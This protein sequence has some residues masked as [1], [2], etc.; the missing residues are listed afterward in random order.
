VGSR[1]LDACRLR[2]V[3]RTPIWLMRQAGR[4]L[5]EYRAVRERHTLLEICG[6][7]EVTTQVTLQP[8]QRFPLD[9]AIVFAD[10]LLPLV[11]MGAS[12]R[13]AKDEGPVIDRG[14]SSPA[15]VERLR[16]VV[17]EAALAPTL[18]ALRMIRHELRPD[19]ALIGFAGAPFTLASYLIEGGTSRRFLRTKRF[20]YHE[21]SAFHRLMEKLA[22]VTA[23]WLVAQVR[24][25]AD[26]VQVFD[27]WVGWLGAEDYRTFVLPHMPPIFEAVRDT[28][29]PSIHFG[30][31]TGGLLELVRDAGGDVIGL[32]WRTRLDDGWRRVGSSRGVQGNLDP[33]VLLAPHNEIE[34][35]AIAVLAAAD[36]QPGHIF[37]LGHGILPD[38][39]VD[40][41][42]VLIDT[43][44][45]SAAALA[46]PAPAA[47]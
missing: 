41:V 16:P 3:D 28:G 39:P 25:G 5:P 32:D 8:L 19:I 12:L 40:A 9:A 24:A 1:L 7:S 29:A 46:S 38:T 36:G 37:N 22:C 33:A 26:V 18:E 10:I 31:D 44:L 34:Q 13:F 11:P 23:D 15:D 45:A 2:P 42:H 6:L 4:Y 35:R 30:V 43:V 27:S 14:V 47:S 21:P 17:P 20:M